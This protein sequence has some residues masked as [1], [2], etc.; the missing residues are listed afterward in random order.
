MISKS[1]TAAIAM[2]ALT[3]VPIERAQ[4]DT[5]GGFVAGAVIGGVVGHQIGKNQ[6]Q[7]RQRVV[8]SGTSSAVRA[9]RREI[10]TSLNYFGFPAGT[11]DGVLGKRSRAAISNY[12]AHMGYP[13]T[14]QLTAFEQDFLLTSYR[15]AIAGGATTN[16]QIAA[17]P[18]GPKGLLWTY[19]DQ[20][21]GVG[22]STTLAATNPNAPAVTTV[23][24]T[25]PTTAT[26]TTQQPIETA[27][28]LQPL[29][30]FLGN[31]AAPQ[32]S[33]ASHCN[34]V[35]LVTTSNGGFTNA[36]NLTD[37][38]FA[39]NEQFCLARTYAISES[40]ELV[41]KVNGFTPDQIE[42]QCKGFGPALEGYVASLSAKASAEVM[43]DV[44]TFAGSSGM[45]A[46]Q[47]SGTAKI[48]L[49]VGYRIDDMQVAVGSGL[50]LAS[51]GQ[52]VYGELMGH[53]LL[54][55]F[56]TAENATLAQEWYKLGFDALA[57]GATPV[58]AP[59]QTERP[60]LLQKAALSLSGTANA[61]NGGATALPV[62]TVSD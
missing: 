1:L 54:G 12:Q 15:R 40:E 27:T 38:S 36:D 46:E 13:A 37:A 53:H 26:G 33:L 48:C 9:E 56:G 28:A 3:A 44:A 23:V 34:Q 57:A 14:G 62:F 8:T 19:R 24:V 61:S 22:T 6:K 5:L 47:L 50:L 29:P 42:Q 21:A 2:A 31:S 59:G 58:F 41:A 4:A 55:G 51:L 39:M 25:Q 7:Q 18:Q 35:N 60:A 30:N 45:S 32:L 11:P 20:A 49:G 52:P 17:N 43:G 16:Q 10:Q